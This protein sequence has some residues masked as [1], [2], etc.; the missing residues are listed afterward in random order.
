MSA[1][2]YHRTLYYALSCTILYIIHMTVCY[3]RLRPGFCCT[4]DR[5]LLKPQNYVETLCRKTCANDLKVFG[6][7]VGDLVF[8]NLRG[9]MVED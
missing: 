7:R 4:R 5:W 9:V 2:V 8:L 1:T 3:N 6:L